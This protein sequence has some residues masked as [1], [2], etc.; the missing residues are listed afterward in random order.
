MCDLCINSRIIISENGY[1]SICCLS[2]KEAMECIMNDY[3][4]YLSAAYF[5]N[6]EKGKETND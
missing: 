6:I 2:E 3:S 1:H 4:R 5:S